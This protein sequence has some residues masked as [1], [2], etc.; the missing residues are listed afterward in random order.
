MLIELSSEEFA[1]QALFMSLTATPKE[2]LKA[3]TDTEGNPKL[4]PNGQPTF[5]TGLKALIL[6][7]GTPKTE[8]RGASVNVCHPL[9]LAFSGT[10]QPE[11]RVWV[12]HYLTNTKQLGVSITVE[13]LVPVRPTSSL[14]P[15]PTIEEGKQ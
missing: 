11:G 9:D 13:K 5:S 12:T 2:E 15:M 4:A 10:Y 6:A 1:Q 8:V 7:N 3:R 14:P